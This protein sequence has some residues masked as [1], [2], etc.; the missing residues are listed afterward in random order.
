M[1][2]RL[3]LLRT[4]SAFKKISRGQ[5]DLA[6]LKPHVMGSSFIVEVGANSGSD[7]LEMLNSFPSSRLICFE[8]DPRAIAQWKKSITNERSELREIAISNYVGTVRFNQSGGLPPGVSAEEFPE[9]WHLSGS[10]LPPKNHTIVHTWSTFENFLEVDCETLDHALGDIN[11]ERY[12]RF[13]VGL[14]WADV[15]GAERQLIEGAR[16]TLTRTR[17]LY[18]EYSNDELYEGQV[19]LYSLL[20]LLPEFEIAKIWTNDVLLQ[21]RK[22]RRFARHA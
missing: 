22:Y 16:D 5:I 3:A 9:G 14:I 13:P 1:P 10:V 2:T 6:E 19:S 21:N 17:F 8:P 12:E 15:Q 20:S 4:R 7:S 18:T 11:W